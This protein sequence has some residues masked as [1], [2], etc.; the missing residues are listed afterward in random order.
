MLLRPHNSCSIQVAALV[1]VGCKRLGRHDDDER[2][3]GRNADRP[4]AIEPD[5]TLSVRSKT[6]EARVGTPA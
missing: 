3:D 1:E 5:G 4:H 2:G 6:V